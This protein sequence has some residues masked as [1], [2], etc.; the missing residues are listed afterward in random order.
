MLIEPDVLCRKNA[1]DIVDGEN[2]LKPSGVA[3]AARKIAEMRIM[4]D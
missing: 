2:Q 1:H 4:F 3:L